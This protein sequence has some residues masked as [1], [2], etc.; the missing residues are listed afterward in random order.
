MYPELL[1]ISAIANIGRRHITV[2]IFVAWILKNRILSASPKDRPSEYRFITSLGFSKVDA[3]TTVRI[4]LTDLISNTVIAEAP[5][6]IFLWAYFSY[7]GV[8]ALM[9][10]A[11]E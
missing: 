4:R 9:S 5:Q 10:L 7:N 3:S 8:L 1:L 6:L 2:L 11:R